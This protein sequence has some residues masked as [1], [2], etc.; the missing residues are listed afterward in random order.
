MV[1]RR[2]SLLAAGL[3]VAAVSGCAKE[4]IAHQQTEAQAIRIMNL[5]TQEGVEVTKLKD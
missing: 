4:V 3:A 5:L 1:R 2:L